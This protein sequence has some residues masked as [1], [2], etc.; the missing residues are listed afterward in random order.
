MW[1]EGKLLTFINTSVVNSACEPQI[2]MLF[3]KFTIMARYFD[4]RVA[5]FLSGKILLTSTG[6]KI[7]MD[8]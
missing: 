6:L 2:S 8:L 1:L 3:Y 7:Y 4:A 5:W